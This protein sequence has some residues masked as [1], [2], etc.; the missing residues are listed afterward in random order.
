MAKLSHLSIC[1]KHIIHTTK[2]YLKK[3]HALGE[4]RY[5]ASTRNSYL[6]VSIG[7][8]FLWCSECSGFL[9]LPQLH[10]NAVFVISLL[11]DY[12]NNL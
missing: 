7:Y 6:T 12:E 9:F 8:L 3:V 1:L 4:S 5:I 2:Y 11:R 10:K